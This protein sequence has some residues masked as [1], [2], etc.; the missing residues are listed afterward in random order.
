EYASFLVLENDA[1]YQRWSIARRNATRV[2]RDD[3]ARARLTAQLQSLRDAALSKLGPAGD[4]RPAVLPRTTTPGNSPDSTAASGPVG[5]PLPGD[6]NFAQTPTMNP[7]SNAPT[8]QFQ[9]QP[10]NSNSGNGRNGG[11][12]GGGGGGALDPLSGLAALGLA[13]TAFVA[14]RRRPAARNA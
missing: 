8:V 3:A 9:P 13:A 11:A 4:A 7:S 10:G 14:R 6:L 1:E 5:Q 2:Q 12:F